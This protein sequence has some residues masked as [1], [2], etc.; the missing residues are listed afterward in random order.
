[1]CTLHNKLQPY[2]APPTPIPVHATVATPP[3][4]QKKKKKKKKL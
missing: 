2:L 4:P 1:M 3:P